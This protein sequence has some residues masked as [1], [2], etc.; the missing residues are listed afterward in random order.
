MGET[1]GIVSFS[2]E[3]I[4][5]LSIVAKIAKTAFTCGITYYHTMK[6]MAAY[7]MG[8]DAASHAHAREARKVLAAIMAMPMEATFYFL[9]ALV[10]TRTCRE[11]AKPDRADAL[12]TLAAYRKKL[13]FW[14]DNCPA[15]FA[16]KHALV[17]AEIAE[18]EGDE[19]SAE[20]LFEQAIES[21]RANGFIHWEAM[22]NEAAARFHG[23]RG[24]KTIS[25][26]YLRE[27]HSGYARWGAQSKVRQLEQLYPE[28]R[29]AP[30]AGISTGTQ[31]ID[32]HAIIQASQAISGQILL[33]NLLKTL[34]R[35]VL[36]N[37]G[38]QQGYL[39]L[40]RKEALTL[41]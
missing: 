28:L 26:A 3:G 21:A 8:D 35:I 13:A 2:G 39:L 34:M 14:A 7:L 24:L 33:D 30:P 37:A 1:D 23:A 36:E 31:D 12:E 25:R 4:G 41:A 18:I 20:G 27:A 16:G 32:I 19:L 5:E 9:H 15:N 6:M 17:S 40:I 22:A 29:E 38:A 10:L 11:A